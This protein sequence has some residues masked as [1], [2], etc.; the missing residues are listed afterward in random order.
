MNNELISNQNKINPFL[1]YKRSVF[2]WTFNN[3][4]VARYNRD[5]ALTAMG[6]L[7]IGY[8]V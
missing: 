5:I 7:N 3:A 1:W 4:N 2:F 6:Q 8:I